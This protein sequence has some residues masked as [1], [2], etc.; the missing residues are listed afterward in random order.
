MLPS[1]AARSA[2]ITAKYSARPAKSSSAGSS[3]QAAIHS[4]ASRTSPRSMQAW[5][6][7]PGDAYGRMLGGI[8]A[9]A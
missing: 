8:V 4:R 6:I 7:A 3:A 2:P 9:A 5:E 1:T